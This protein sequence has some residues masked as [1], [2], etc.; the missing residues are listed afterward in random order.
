MHGHHKVVLLHLLCQCPITREPILYQFPA[1]RV[2]ERLLFHD[3][4]GR[5]H[6]SPPTASETNLL[7]GPNRLGQLRSER[8][9]ADSHGRRKR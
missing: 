5:T 9:T 3:C 1:H 6:M 2:I 7:A 8:R 4:L